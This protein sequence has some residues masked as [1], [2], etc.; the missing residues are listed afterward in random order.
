MI[1]QKESLKELKE[2]QMHFFENFSELLKRPTK[3]EPNEVRNAK[4]DGESLKWNLRHLIEQVYKL[5]LLKEGIDLSGFLDTFV[6][7]PISRFIEQTEK[8]WLDDKLT[9]ALMGHYSS[10]KTSVINC[11][12]DQNFPVR[13]SESTALAT[14]LSY[15]KNTSMVRLVDKGGKI[16]EIRDEKDEA[17]LM[18]YRVSN[19]FPFA[20][21]FDYMQKDCDN[22]LLKQMTFID[23]P[24]LFTAKVGHSNPTITALNQAD[25]VVWCER[26]DRGGESFKDKNGFPIEKV[27]DKTVY[28]I[29]TFAD[30][31]RDPE[32]TAQRLLNTAKQQGVK[33]KGYFFFGKSESVQDS[34]SKSFERSMQGEMNREK[35]NPLGVIYGLT[36]SMVKML[37][38]TL[39]SIKKEIIEA[40]KEADEILNKFTSSRELYI[41]EHNN[42][43]RRLNSLI[44]TFNNRCSGSV[45]CGGAS[46]AMATTIN[47]SMSSWNNMTDAFNELDA[48]KLATYGVIQGSLSDMKEKQEQIESLKQEFINILNRFKND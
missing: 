42:A 16:Q 22:N 33:I 18:D 11:L 2:R 3:E 32:D 37:S 15:G 34:F 43:L 46:G 40:E 8:P 9:V 29:F 44:D 45:F 41:S 36:N 21:V 7:A 25:I 48:S 23:T 31:V 13:S 12:F 1:E 19:N 38:D 26:L 14:Y 30:E 17:G 39:H 4:E 35:Y 6:D 27:G 28:V 10:G 24:G 47:Q 5:D 20:R